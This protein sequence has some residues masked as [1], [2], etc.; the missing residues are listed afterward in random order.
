MERS[1][2]WIEQAKGDILHAKS[3]K[4]HGF[5]E[6]SCF[7]SQQAAE[8]AVKAVFQKMGAEAWGHSVSDLLYELS[9]KYEVPKELIDYALELDKVYIPARYPDA[10]PS[11][12]PKTRYIEEEANRLLKYAQRIVQFCENLLSK[13]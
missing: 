5:Y 6:W 9:Q 2:D 3:D 12:S 1:R 11:G 4:E 10:H 7:S 13:I 8:K